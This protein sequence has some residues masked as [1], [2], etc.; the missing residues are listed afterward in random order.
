MNRL[1]A[2]VILFLSIGVLVA[3]ANP[4]LPNPP[5]PTGALRSQNSP[6]TYIYDQFGNLLGVQSK[7]GVDTYFAVTQTS[8]PSTG[9]FT[10]LTATSGVF[11]SVSSVSGTFT[12]LTGAL[13]GN[14]SSA[15]ALA[16]TPTGCA[17]SAVATTIA[18]NG[19]LGCAYVNYGVDVAVSGVL[20]STSDQSV[21]GK[22]LVSATAPTISEGFGGDP[23]IVAFNTSAFKITVGGG[24]AASGV[25]ALPTAPNG[26]VCS[27]SDITTT[28]PEV[29]LSKQTSDSAAS[30]AFAVYSESGVAA[31]WSA[32]DELH[33]ECKPY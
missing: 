27:A 17:T 3:T 24:G 32:A 15:S 7:N 6:Q 10:T 16:A 4:F 28:S 22:L 26:W 25:V 33:V 13:T 11:S 18:S 8:T 23:G 29:F 1:I 12:T 2:G 5:L 19:N 20:S 9:V 31:A 21:N 30:A 14:A